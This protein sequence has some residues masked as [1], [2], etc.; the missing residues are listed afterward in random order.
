MKFP[1]GK[2]T[3]R[4]MRYSESFSGTEA[5]WAAG[6]FHTL[7]RGGDVR[8]LMRMPIAGKVAGKFCRMQLRTA[9]QPCEAQQRLPRLD[10]ETLMT[11]AG[12]HPILGWTALARLLRVHRTTLCGQTKRWRER[13]EHKVLPSD[14]DVEVAAAE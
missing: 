11:A 10:D 12:L 8:Y 4:S 6:L 3:G 1:R 2:K 14:G 9:G 13:A 7:L 5:E